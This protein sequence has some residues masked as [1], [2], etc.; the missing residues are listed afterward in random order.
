MNSLTSNHDCGCPQTDKNTEVFVSLHLGLDENATERRIGSAAQRDLQHTTA[1]ASRPTNKHP[2]SSAPRRQVKHRKNDTVRLIRS[3]KM[4][5]RLPHASH[6]ILLSPCPLPASKTSNFLL[7][8]G[9]LMKAC[10]L[11]QECVRCVQMDERYAGVHVAI[12][13]PAHAWWCVLAE[14]ACD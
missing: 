1:F 5:Q 7:D 9:H 2:H 4:H 11:W 14:I 8:S 12:A 3:R 10:R 6:S 13:F